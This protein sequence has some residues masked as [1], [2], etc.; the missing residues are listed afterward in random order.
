M[1]VFSELRRRNVFR[2][3]AAY[4]VFGWLV[5]QIADIVFP[6]LDLPEWTITLIVV[7]LAIGF[8]PVLIVSWVYELT[9]EGLKRESDV[10]QTRSVT[11]AAG[12]RLDLITIAMLVLVLAVIVVNR[13]LPDG[14]K[15]DRADA[16][17]HEYSIAV[18]AFEDL[19]DTQDQEYFGDGLAE[20]LLNQLAKVEDF[21]VAGRTS[22]FAFKGRD[23]DLRVIGGKLNVAT[24]LEGSVRKAGDQLR[25][26]AQLN[27]VADGYHLWSE[28]YDGKLEN[29]FEFQEQI[30][31][32]VVTALKSTLLGTTEPVN[33]EPQAVADT[34]LMSCI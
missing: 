24:I 32:S 25:I 31:R 30:A 28:T 33:L 10:D 3:V 5:L 2:V 8:I 7:L 23:D 27:D 16:A 22:A 26:T 18:L 14:Q 21:R 6:A 15:D 11:R 29:I 19:S 12:R 20:E 17:A 9:P 1:N 4:L 34:R 13:M